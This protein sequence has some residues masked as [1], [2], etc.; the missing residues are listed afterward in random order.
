MGRNTF[1]SAGEALCAGLYF[2]Y[3]PEF[4][5]GHAVGISEKAG[6]SGSA[7]NTRQLANDVDGIVGSLQQKGNTLQ[8]VVVDEVTRRHARSTGMNGLFQ[9]DCIGV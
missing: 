6:Q 2:R 5:A 8:T 4:T 7:G 3:L 1:V 9:I